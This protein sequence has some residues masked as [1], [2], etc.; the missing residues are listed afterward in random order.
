MFKKKIKLNFTK[1]FK[2][3]ISFVF[4]ITYFNLYNAQTSGYIT[5]HVLDLGVGKPGA[6][7]KANLYIKKTVGW[8]TYWNLIISEF[9]NQY[10]RFLN[11]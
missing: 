5:S 8:K 4:L 11:L 7:I 10:G 3:I 9:S 1:M 6:N 2:S